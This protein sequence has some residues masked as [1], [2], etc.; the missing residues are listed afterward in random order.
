MKDIITI[1]LVLIIGFFV[2]SY[3]DRHNI[4][5]LRSGEVKGTVE[6]LSTMNVKDAVDFITGDIANK[7]GSEFDR[8][9]LKAMITTRQAEI[10]MAQIASVTSTRKEIRDSAKEIVTKQTIELNQLKAWQ[11][12]WFG[13][14]K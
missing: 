4:N 7:V 5:P 13:D 14:T 6:K 11:K 3:L 8:E 1:I 12:E 10:T 2:G 9:Y